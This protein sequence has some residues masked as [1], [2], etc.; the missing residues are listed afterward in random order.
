MAPGVIEP[1]VACDV[2]GTAEPVCAVVSEPAL[3]PDAV[4]ELHPHASDGDWLLENPG[5]LSGGAPAVVPGPA[6]RRAMGY[7]AL[8]AEAAQVPAGAT[9]CSGYPRW[10]GRW[11]PSGTRMRARPGSG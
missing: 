9:G 7:G 4:T 3:D 5:W 1:G 6:R 10:R 2:I 11:R 8:T